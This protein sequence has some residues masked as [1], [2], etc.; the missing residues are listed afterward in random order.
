MDR[1]AR[2]AEAFAIQPGAQQRERRL[3]RSDRV[4]HAYGPHARAPEPPRPAEPILAFCPTAAVARQLL[5]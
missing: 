4:L 3:Q 2:K 1:I 5:L